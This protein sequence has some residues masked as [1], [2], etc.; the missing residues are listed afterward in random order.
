MN[1]KQHQLHVHAIHS[2]NS[3]DVTNACVRPVDSEGHA[4]TH[5][6]SRDRSSPSKSIHIA[7]CY[8]SDEHSDSTVARAMA[9]AP[10]KFK[11]INSDNVG[12]VPGSDISILKIIP[13][14]TG[15]G[16]VVVI[17]AAIAHTAAVRARHTTSPL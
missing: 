4:L 11:S 13:T 12:K 17:D 9:V 6:S 1:A 5:S 8:V 2:A 3:C 14:S 10:E 16:G 7:S 15:L